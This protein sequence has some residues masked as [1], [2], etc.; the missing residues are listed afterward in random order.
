MP[1]LAG[2]CQRFAVWFAPRQVLIRRL[3]RRMACAGIMLTG[4]GAASEL[5]PFT[6]DGCSLFPDRAGGADWCH[7]CVAHD[8]LYWRGGPADQRLQADQALRS[9]VRAAANSPALADMMYAG[10][11]L[12]GSAYLPTW[13]RWGYG[14]TYGRFNQS[15]TPEESVIADRL[16]ADYE[17]RIGFGVCPGVPAAAFGPP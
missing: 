12:G 5:R 14:W 6:T 9:C 3:L 11:R 15:L 1:P 8:R 2:S 17:A 13:F 7:C 16:E 10:V 4:C